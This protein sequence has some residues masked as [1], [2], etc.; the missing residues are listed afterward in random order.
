MEDQSTPEEGGYF[1][2]HNMHYSDVMIFEAVQFALHC[3]PIHQIGREKDGNSETNLCK[4][5]RM[6]RKERKMTLTLFAAI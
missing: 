5:R 4:E 6:H 1:C 3:I 2:Q